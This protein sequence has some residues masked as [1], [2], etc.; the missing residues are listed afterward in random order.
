MK[1]MISYFY[2]IRFF[3]PNMIPLSTAMWDPKWFHDNKGSSHKFFDKNGV[4]NGVR[5]EPFVPANE[6]SGLCRGRENCSPGIEPG[7]CPF[8]Y[9]Y[10][11]QLC[12]LDF[13]EIMKRFEKLGK[14]VQSDRGFFEEPVMV[15]I[16]YET[17]QNPCSER[18]TIK[19]WF[20]KHNYELE[21]FVP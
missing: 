3:K 19:A 1:V 13:N 10:F 5:A 7:E 2:Q 21:E 18:G 17:P 8:L 12:A 16:V 9:T 15:L 20:A 11:D 4:L 6:C 14:T